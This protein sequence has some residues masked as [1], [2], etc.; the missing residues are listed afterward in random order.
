MPFGRRDIMASFVK[1]AHV[2][3]QNVVAKSAG[4]KQVSQQSD[5]PNNTRCCKLSRCSRVFTAT[6]MSLQCRCA[7]PRTAV[8][9]PATMH[10]ANY[11]ILTPLQGPSLEAKRKTFSVRVPRL[12]SRSNKFRDRV[13]HTRQSINII[14]LNWWFDDRPTSLTII[15]NVL[16][17]CEI[18]DLRHLNFVRII[19]FSNQETNKM[20]WRE[21]LKSPK[22]RG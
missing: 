17:R 13:L 5:T 4:K 8:A 22:L 14:P 7:P 9:P 6:S 18:W 1:M 19:I 20:R 11:T 16:C 2:L 21:T 12:G 10:S 15:R 3:N